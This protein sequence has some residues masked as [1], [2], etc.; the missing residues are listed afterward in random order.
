LS[1]C[2][3][4]RV[5]VSPQF[6]FVQ[7]IQTC[8]RLKPRVKFGIKR[9]SLTA[10]PASFVPRELPVISELEGEVAPNP[11]YEFKVAQEYHPE[12]GQLDPAVASPFDLKGP[13]RFWAEQAKLSKQL[14]GN[15]NIRAIDLCE[16]CHIRPIRRVGNG[17]HYPPFRHTCKECEAAHQKEIHGAQLERDRAKWRSGFYKFSPDLD[18]KKASDLA[19]RR[20]KRGIKICPRCSVGVVELRNQICKACRD[21]HAAT[22]ADWNRSY[23][24]QWA[25]KK[26]AAKGKVSLEIKL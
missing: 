2:T 12:A 8:P 24:R 26:R 10:G 5:V 3:C 7:H 1:K 19:Y 25:R 14:G 17:H 6:S 18:R 23:Q 13:G 11:E 20:R 21:K 15:L 9:Y 22:A 16:T 4:P